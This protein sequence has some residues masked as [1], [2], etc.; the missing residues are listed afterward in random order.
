MD[1]LCDHQEHARGDDQHPAKG[2]CW[3]PHGK[4]PR[5]PCQP[6]VMLRARQLGP[7]GG[8]RVQSSGLDMLG[9]SLSLEIV[10]H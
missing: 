3:N 5:Q 4:P 8:G 10:R 9:Q 1:K 2:D 6:A 7:A